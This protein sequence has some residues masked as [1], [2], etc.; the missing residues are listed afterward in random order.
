[1]VEFRVGPVLPPREA[2]R[3]GR[4]D[5]HDDKCDKTLAQLSL[6]PW[7]R[8]SRLR[9]CRILGGTGPELSLAGRWRTADPEKVAPFAE[10]L[11]LRI[12]FTTMLNEENSLQPVRSSLVSQVW[13][14][15]VKVL[16]NVSSL[17]R[18]S[19]KMSRTDSDPLTQLLNK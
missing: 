15:F 4:E 19:N 17:T 14:G 6:T 1:M 18:N 5:N 3:S 2:C 11:D 10:A 7:I 16:Y 13:T 9:S 12:I 8:E